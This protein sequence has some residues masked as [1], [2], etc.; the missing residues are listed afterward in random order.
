[1]LPEIIADAPPPLPVRFVVRMGVPPLP[2]NTVKGEDAKKEKLKE[3]PPPPRDSPPLPPPPV[4]Q[5][6]TLQPPGEGGT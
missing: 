4:I 1:M 2:T 3:A 5:I 6:V